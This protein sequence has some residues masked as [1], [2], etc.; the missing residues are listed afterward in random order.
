MLSRR[1]KSS[2]V[3]PLTRA[4]SSGS[5]GHEAHKTIQRGDVAYMGGSL[6]DY[7]QNYPKRLMFNERVIPWISKW[8]PSVDI[9]YFVR[10]DRHSKLALYYW[11]G[12]AK[13]YRFLFLGCCW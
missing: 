9:A 13:L 11:L 1:L 4:L 7:K 10:N 12:R 6:E 2:L 3:A 5:H 8:F